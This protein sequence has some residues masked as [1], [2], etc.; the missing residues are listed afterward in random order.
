MP[1]DVNVPGVGGSYPRYLTNVNGTLFFQANGRRSAELNCG[2][3]TALPPVPQTVADINPTGGC[4]PN[5]ALTNVAG[6]LFFRA[7]DG[8][9]G[10]AV[11]GEQ[12]PD[13][14]TS[15]GH[16]PQPGLYPGLLS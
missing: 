12:R 5:N 8:V 9:H 6:T 11:V 3:A 2:R 15:Y 4:V 16:G 10:Y 1:S 13:T 14:G 7:N